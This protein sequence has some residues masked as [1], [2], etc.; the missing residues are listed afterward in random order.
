LRGGVI[1]PSTIFFITSNSLLR[2]QSPPERELVSM[3]PEAK[4]NVGAP[5][6]SGSPT[7]T[8]RAHVGNFPL[9]RP[10]RVS[11]SGSSIGDPEVE[12]LH[13][14]SKVTM[15]FCGVTSRWTI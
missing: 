6:K 14:P 7:G 2:G 15:M 5:K 4:K 11:P 10:E 13:A 8:A 12:Q 1:L 9:Q 3:I